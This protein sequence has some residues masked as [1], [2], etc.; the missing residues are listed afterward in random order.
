MAQVRCCAWRRSQGDLQ[1]I[2]S[3]PL[4]ILSA[5]EESMLSVGPTPY[6]AGP[7]V[8][9]RRSKALWRRSLCFLEQVPSLLAQVRLSERDL[10]RKSASYAFCWRMSCTFSR[11]CAKYLEYLRHPA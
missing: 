11:T 1:T 8:S 7:R 3:E 9:R 6:G 4:V 2:L 5:S 10:H